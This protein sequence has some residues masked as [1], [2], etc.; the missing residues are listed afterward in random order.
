MRGVA[1]EAERLENFVG[2]VKDGAAG[3]LVHAA[4]LHS[5]EPVLHYVRKTYAVGAAKGIELFY[6]SHGRELLAVDG[7]GFA[8]HEGYRDV[9][10]FVRRR[11]GT[12]AHLEESG[13]IVLRLVG[14]IF[15]IESF[16]RK[17][18]QVLVLA[19]IGLAVDLERDIVRLGVIDL[20]LA[21]LDIP[22]TPGSDYFHSGSERLDRQLETHLVVPLSRAAMADRV[23]TFLFRDLDDALCD[24]GTGKRGAEQVFVLIDRARFHRRINV[25]LDKFFAQIFDI[26]FGSA[27]FESLLFQ[28]FQFA[29]LPHVRGNGDHFA[30]VIVLFEPGDDNGSIQPARISE[31][32]LFDLFFLHGF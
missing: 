28:T 10:G 17:M 1:V 8:L 15:E 29:L 14:R 3:R 22:Y 24:D 19:V 21:A 11:E 2:A 16:V 25:I 31:H 6:D 7:Y 12:Y 23:R 30:V 9:G 26:Q 18:P 20:L 32:H 5:D 4:R 27:R 13:F